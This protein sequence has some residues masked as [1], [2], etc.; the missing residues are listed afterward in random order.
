MDLQLGASIPNTSRA[1]S[2]NWADKVEEEE[3]A[4]KMS[5]ATVSFAT[6]DT[7]CMSAHEDNEVGQVNEEIRT[8]IGSDLKDIGIK[9]A[10]SNVRRRSN[11]N[12]DI[13][14]ANNTSSVGGDNKEVLIEESVSSDTGNGKDFVNGKYFGDGKDF[15]TVTPTPSLSSSANATTISAS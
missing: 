9:H 11:S 5:V 3:N 1:T 6:L 2:F 7:E 8:N 10:A 14:N 12:S 15:D 4:K 13:E